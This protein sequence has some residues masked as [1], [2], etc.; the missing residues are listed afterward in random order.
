[1]LLSIIA[2]AIMGVPIFQHVW[3]IGRAVLR[4][5]ILI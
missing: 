2:L 3:E 1:V 5:L 4:L